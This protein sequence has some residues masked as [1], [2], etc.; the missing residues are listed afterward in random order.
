M[1]IALYWMYNI[2]TKCKIHS[3]GDLNWEK[4]QG[5]SMIVL[6]VL[7]SSFVL[8]PVA[9]AGLTGNIYLTAESSGMDDASYEVVLT[10]ETPVVALDLTEY[11]GEAPATLHIH[12]H[13]RTVLLRVDVGIDSL[14]W[15]INTTTDYESQW[16]LY[17]AS[18]ISTYQVIA[19][20]KL[21]ENATVFVSI[22]DTTPVISLSYYVPFYL[23]TTSISL[24]LVTWALVK[25]YRIDQLF[26]IPEEPETDD[27]DDESEESIIV[28]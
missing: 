20:E 1:F 7:I 3:S 6:L 28:D 18:D 26:K 13:N 2:E 16:W 22:Q 27:N 5:P 11:T 12:T 17:L 15:E 8:A 25:A 10:N 23:G 4:R 14:C 24:V 9:I 21:S 19:V